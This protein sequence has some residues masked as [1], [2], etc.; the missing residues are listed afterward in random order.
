MVPVTAA[1]DE[2][3]ARLVDTPSAAAKDSAPM[4]NVCF[5]LDRASCM[6]YGV[7]KARDDRPGG[8]AIISA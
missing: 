6:M 7:L 3:A 1:G 4:S 8:V 5:S 2:R